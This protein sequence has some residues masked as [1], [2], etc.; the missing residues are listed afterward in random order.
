[1]IALKYFQALNCRLK[2]IN[3]WF[4]K[5]IFQI[6]NKKKLNK[7]KK[8]QNLKLNKISLSKAHFLYLKKVHLHINLHNKNKMK[9]FKNRLSY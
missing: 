2:M 9:I 7:K 3:P 4:F 5:I 8:I 6:L 1:M